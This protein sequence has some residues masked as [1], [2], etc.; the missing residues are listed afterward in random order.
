MVFVVQQGVQDGE[1][2]GKVMWV[3]AGEF[4]EEFLVGMAI[5]MAVISLVVMVRVSLVEVVFLEDFLVS[6]VGVVIPVEVVA[7]LALM[8]VVAFLALM[9]VVAFLVLMEV[10]DL[11]GLVDRVDRV[12]DFQDLLEE[13]IQLHRLQDSQL[14]LGA[15]WHSRNQFALS[16]C[17]RCKNCRSLK[18]AL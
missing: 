17:R 10:V 12:V 7:F 18:L 5:Y 1:L 9:E 4:M 11:V 6:L 16:T 8:E 13:V 14:G 2:T 15:S 3:V